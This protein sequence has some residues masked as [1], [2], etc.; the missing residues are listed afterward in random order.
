M[1]V[2]HAI[3]SVDTRRF[4]YR[5]GVFSAEASDLPDFDTYLTLVSHKTGRAEAFYI[6]WV[7]RDREGEVQS[8]HL[9]PVNES[10]HGVTVT[11]WND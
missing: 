10:L 4:S 3:P 5:D 1:N 7:E 9:R 6:D 11:V 2:E 8:W